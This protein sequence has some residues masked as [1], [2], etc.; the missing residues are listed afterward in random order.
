[1]S[2]FQDYLSAI[3]N[4][5]QERLQQDEYN[6]RDWANKESGRHAGLKSLMSAGVGAGL[7]Y[8]F[9]PLGMTAGKAA[10]LGGGLGL[11]GGG[12]AVALPYMVNRGTPTS[13]PDAPTGSG[14][15]NFNPYAEGFGGVDDKSLITKPTPG[16]GVDRTWSLKKYLEDRKMFGRY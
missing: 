9:P 6:Y 8:A 15:L 3:N 5:K 1:M 7:M 14:G 13:T 2:L 11:M 12:D 4:L 10:L 16:Y